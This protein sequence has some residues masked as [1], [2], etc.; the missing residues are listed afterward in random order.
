MCYFS[1]GTAIPRMI[2]RWVNRKMSIVGILTMRI[3][4]DT[5]A[6][7]PWAR[8]TT[9]SFDSIAANAHRYADQQHEKEAGLTA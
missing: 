5:A 4:A 3:E 8:T 6:G 7:R 1:A 2:V 9:R